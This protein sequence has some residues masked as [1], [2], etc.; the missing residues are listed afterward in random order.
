MRRAVA[1]AAAVAVLGGVSLTGCQ[2]RPGA[3]ERADRT[4]Q[5]GDRTGTGTGPEGSSAGDQV[6]GGSIDTELDAVEALLADVDAQL[7]EDS[8]APEDAD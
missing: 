5:V 6:S 1:L 3:G 4:S 2:A 7:A 8:R